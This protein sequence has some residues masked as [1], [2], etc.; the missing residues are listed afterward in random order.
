MDVVV[1]KTIKF[2][3]GS[4]IGGGTTPSLFNAMADAYKIQQ[5]RGLVLSP[6]QLWYLATL[7]GANALS[8]RSETGSLEAG[9]SADFVVLDLEA[10]PLMSLR[11][12]RAN[13]VEDFLAG[14]IFIG[15]D[16]MVLETTIAGRGV[17]SRPV[18]ADL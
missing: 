7:G 18:T 5:V 9:K 14:L 17:H 3:L 4:D 6:F 11:A 12:S 8:L 13:S 15:D 10:T 1:E 2:G 16:R